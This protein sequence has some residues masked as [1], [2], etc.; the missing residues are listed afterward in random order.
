MI[1]RIYA[2]DVDNK[3]QA[4]VDYVILPVT[5]TIPQEKQL[6]FLGRG[7]IIDNLTNQWIFIR[8]AFAFCPPYV[9]G[10]SIP[11]SG[12]QK[13]TILFQTPTGFSQQPT[14][15][16]QQAIIRITAALVGAAPGVPV[17]PAPTRWAINHQPATGVKASVTKAAVS[18]VV[19]VA[20]A[21]AVSYE[22]ASSATIASAIST[23]EDG[24]SGSPNQLLT[25]QMLTTVTA[26]STDRSQLSGLGLKGTVST[27]MTIEFLAGL[28]GFIES[29]SLVGY[30]A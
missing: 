29:V 17:A 18:G 23:I 20:D 30:D 5:Q 28:A 8:E 15:S 2:D 10:R 22:N 9:S 16:G 27:A 25:L 4:Q 14:I 26:G 3:Q 19:H 1:G 7:I 11:I 13:I 24:A 21:Y 6:A 12:S